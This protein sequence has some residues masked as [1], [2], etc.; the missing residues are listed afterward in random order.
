[1]MMMMKTALLHAY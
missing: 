1:M